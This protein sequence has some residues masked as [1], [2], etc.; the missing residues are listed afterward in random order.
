MTIVLRLD[1]IKRVYNLRRATRTEVRINLQ[2]GSPPGGLSDTVTGLICSSARLRYR[3]KAEW[4]RNGGTVSVPLLAVL[5][6]LAPG[7]RRRT[8]QLLGSR[9]NLNEFQGLILEPLGFAVS[10]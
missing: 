2:K 3:R 5:H 1:G 8:A 6:L 10:L 9:E 4:V 7:S